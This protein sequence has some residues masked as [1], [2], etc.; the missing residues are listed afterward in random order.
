MYFNIIYIYLIY[1][2]AYYQ[3]IK[4]IVNLD[5]LYMIGVMISVTS[6]LSIYISLNFSVLGVMLCN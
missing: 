4:T 3:M 2:C 1:V 6:S 5:Y